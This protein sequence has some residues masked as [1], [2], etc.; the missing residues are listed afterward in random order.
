MRLFY[1]SSICLLA[2]LAACGQQVNS[3]TRTEADNINAVFGR[4]ET[5]LNKLD[6]S[7]VQSYGHLANN[8]L[9]FIMKEYR[10]TMSL[11]DGIMLSDY[12]RINKGLAYIITNTKEQREEIKKSIEQMDNLMTDLENGLVPKEKQKEY[13]EAEKQAAN[14]ISEAVAKI[15]D[16]YD[17]RIKEFEA[18]NPTVEEF[19][20]S[21]KQNNQNSV[22]EE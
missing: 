9:K 18:L 11:K 13:F 15:M 22:S 12:K 7:L 5:E 2:L 10:D 4:A 17:A 1:L 14:Q 6:T 19:V 16:I 8:H 3:S 20:N 21:I